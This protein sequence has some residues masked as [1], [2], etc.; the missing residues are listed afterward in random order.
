MF[1]QPLFQIKGVQGAPGL[2]G[3]AGVI[4]SQVCA[5]LVLQLISC[6]QVCYL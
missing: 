6:V 2:P 3:E 4:G 5:R 1:A